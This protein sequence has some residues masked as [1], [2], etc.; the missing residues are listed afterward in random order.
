MHK[1]PPIGPF[2]SQMKPVHALQS[3]LFKAHLYIYIYIYEQDEYI[4]QM[5]LSN[6]IPINTLFDSEAH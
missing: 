4:T 5:I 2:L 3:Y 6:K 1:S